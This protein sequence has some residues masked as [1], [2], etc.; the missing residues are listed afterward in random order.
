MSE[1]RSDPSRAPPVQRASLAHHAVPECI[2]LERG[3]HYARV[4]E[5]FS[6]FRAPPAIP[7]CRLGAARSGTAPAHVQPAVQLLRRGARQLERSFR[8]GSSSRRSSLETSRRRYSND[9]AFVYDP[10]RP[11][12]RHSRQECGASSQLSGAARDAF[13]PARPHCRAEQLQGAV[14]LDGCS[15][16]RW[17]A[18]SSTCRRRANVSFSLSN[19]IGARTC[20]STAPATS[21]VGAECSPD[22]SLLLSA[23]LR[24]GGEPLPLRVN[25]ASVQ[26]AAVPRASHAVVL[27]ASM[28]FDLAP[29][30]SSS[31]Y[32]E[33]RFGQEPA[34]IAQP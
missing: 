25:S 13:A 17:T 24:P 7:E 34:G 2:R 11:G 16:S 8:S 3:V 15:R 1:V 5:Q 20:S 12:T 33:H 23:R 30:A 6:G 32:A 28:R 14:E 19:P 29:R 26:R 9:R 31:A 21:R 22:Q 27:T 10:G 4:S 18:R